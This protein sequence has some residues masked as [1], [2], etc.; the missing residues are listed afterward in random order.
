[1][2][3]AGDEA[4]AAYFTLLRARDELAAVIRYAEW[5][6]RERDRLDRFLADGVELDATID[7]RLRR[8]VSHGD[9]PLRELI[10]S[11][12]RVVV[13]ELAKVDARELA[14]QQFAEEC[15]ADLAR[16]RAS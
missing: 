14:A 15:E 4:E 11:R 7:A 10:Q 3:T 8:S 12:R 13:E 6:N 1:V 9:D 5:L 2:R 16:V